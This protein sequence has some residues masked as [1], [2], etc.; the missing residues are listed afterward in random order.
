MDSVLENDENSE[1][2]DV[3]GQEIITNTMIEKCTVE[4]AV[5]KEG[6]QTVLSS[7]ENSKPGE[8][9]PDLNLQSNVSIQTSAEISSDKHTV[10]CSNENEQSDMGE[11]DMNLQSEGTNQDMEEMSA[12][13]QPVLSPNENSEPDPGQNITDLNLPLDVAS[14]E[15]SSRST[16]KKRLAI[17]DSDSENEETPTIVPEVT[18]NEEETYTL[19]SKGELIL[20]TSNNVTKKVS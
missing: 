14:Q 6:S 16:K 15:I 3:M 10:L 12:N 4:T 2:T 9:I 11:N 18:H 8:N 1:T 13:R 19:G 7:N 17:I 20:E 5:N